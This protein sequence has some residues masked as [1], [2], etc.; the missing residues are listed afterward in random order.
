MLPF[1]SSSTEASSSE[2]YEDFLR[3]ELVSL[4][5]RLVQKY[6]AALDRG[7][8]QTSVFSVASSLG[9]FNNLQ[10]PTPVEL[11]TDEDTPCT[12]VDE[13][14]AHLTLNLMEEQDE[15]AGKQFVGRVI[16]LRNIEQPGHLSLRG[17]WQFS[18]AEAHRLGRQRTAEKPEPT[19]FN[20]VVEDD[21]WLQQFVVGPDSAIQF[22]WALLATVFIV[23]DM[24]TIPLEIFP[25]DE[26][27]H[28]TFAVSA[29][30]LVFWVADVP[31][32]FL[33]GS[34]I[35][36]II[37]MRPARLAALYMRSWLL[38]DLMV[39]LVDLALITLEVIRA[40]DMNPLFRSGRFFRTIRLVRLLRLL[41]VGK[42]ERQIMV[43]A[44]R[45]L[46]TYSLM[47]LRV[48]GYLSVML[49][50][51]HLIACCWYGIG[52]FLKDNGR[53]SWLERSEI[54]QDN[55]GEAYIA[56]LHWSLTQFTPATNSI[57]PDS[58]WERFYA[59][60]VILLAMACF[61]SF[62]GSIGTTIT[63]MRTVRR[64]Q[65]LQESKLEVF[66]TERNL[67][68]E[69]FER[70]KSALHKDK[71]ART[72]L[73][74]DEV[75]LIN[76]IPESIKVILHKEMYITSLLTVEIWPSWSHK[77]DADLLRTICQQAMSEHT[78]RPGQ[79]V[80]LPHK[81]CQFVYVIQTG[82]LEYHTLDKET[83][84]CESDTVCCLP[85][86]W[87]E[88][89]HMGRLT[90]NHGTCFYIGIGCRD[91]SML[92][93]SFGGPICEYLKIFG[94]LLL[95]EIEALQA[96]GTEVNDISAQDKISTRDLAD[97]AERFA[98]LKE[99]SASRFTRTSSKDR[100]ENELVSF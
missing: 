64:A 6:Q 96:Q 47:A 59:I 30:S 92:A 77:E 58:A 93:A 9:E 15:V 4:A 67:S 49:A 60:W 83:E 41:R 66:F 39:I 28:V 100:I 53:G 56:A 65:L 78:C 71:Q 29:V 25:M 70:V 90:A 74:E 42:L 85:S 19:R 36:G 3:G 73:R 81:L 55:V 88:W 61:S 97:R 95:S 46:S 94:I 5:D 75:T 2:S 68:L 54:N 38:I 51:N 87:A 37:E 11:E 16:S 98:S 99:R 14:W 26:L 52:V 8:R 57:A 35:R 62:I 20:D 86:L 80:F 24:A 17:S 89:P 50:M 18:W 32:H 13:R 1:P 40:S 45:L 21:S 82:S 27:S 76:G 72:R 79:D 44:H 10:A 48:V 84:D 33:F 22:V 69:L 43:I 23:W 91:F 34:Q 63:S 31:T 12:R 7:A